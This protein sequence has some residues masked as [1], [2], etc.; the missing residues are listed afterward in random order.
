VLKDKTN[1]ASEGR[2]ILQPMRNSEYSTV[3]FWKIED[4]QSRGKVVERAQVIAHRKKK[5]NKH[6]GLICDFVLNLR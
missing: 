4:M 2:L 6:N 5:K 1:K 3:L